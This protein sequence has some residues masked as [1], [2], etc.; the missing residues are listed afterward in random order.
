MK[1]MKQ[2]KI[3]VPKGEVATSVDQAMTIAQ[4]IGFIAFLSHTL[5]KAETWS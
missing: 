3:N 2:Y 5:A 1:L 4:D